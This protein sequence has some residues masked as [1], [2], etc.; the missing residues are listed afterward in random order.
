MSILVSYLAWCSLVI[1]LAKMDGT[2]VIA[3]AGSEEKV[4]F[5]KEIGADVAF[6][7]KTTDTKEVLRKEGPIDM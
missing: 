6:N 1:Q 7:Y 5:M 3:S 2:R 4:N